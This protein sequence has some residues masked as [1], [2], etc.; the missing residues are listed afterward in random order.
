MSVPLKTRE[1]NRE[2]Y[3][4]KMS[5]PVERAKKNEYHRHYNA[6]LPPQKKA[7][8]RKRNMLIMRRPAA[9]MRQ[10]QRGAHKRGLSFELDLAAFTVLIHQ[11]C[12]YCYQSP[13]PTNGVDRYNN[14]E[15]YTA[16]NSV[17][18]CSMC[19]RAKGAIPVEDFLCWCARIAE[20]HKTE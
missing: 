18:C 2:R 14:D 13:D 4:R 8:I 5:D 19:N 11:P 3:R 17:P 9:W 1:R 15:G 6:S 20:A 16:E 10:Y 12:H 7:H